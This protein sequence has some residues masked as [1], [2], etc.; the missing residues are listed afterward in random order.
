MK[1]GQGYSLSVVPL[2]DL[3]SRIL[4]ENPG[5]VRTIWREI[6]LGG[7]LLS[8]GLED[9]LHLLPL[10]LG[11]V[12]GANTLLQELQAT[13]FLSDPEIKHFRCFQWVGI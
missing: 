8:H 13:L 4:L 3:E 10:P 12:V 5:K 9:A 7:S 11:K 1:N 2:V 6:C